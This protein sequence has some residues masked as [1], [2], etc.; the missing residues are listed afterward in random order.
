[1]TRVDM[2]RW[3]VVAY[4]DETGLGSMARDIKAVLGV[5]QLVVPSDRLETNRLDERR[6]HLLTPDMPEEQLEAIIRPLQGIVVLERVNW[7]PRLMA[8]CRRHGVAVVCVPMWE[9]FRGSDA[10]WREGDLF[11]CPSAFCREHV[12]RY[13]FSNA[14]VIPW[15]L[16]ISKLPARNVSGVGR[17]FFHNGGL[18]DSDDRK[19]TRTAISAFTRWRRKDVRLIVRLQK[20]PDTLPCMDD[21]IELKIGNVPDKALLYHEGD[22]ALQPSKME[23]LGFGILEPVVCG[24]P[25]ITLNY[26]PMSEYVIHKQIR[27]GKLPFKR[28][29][30]ARRAAGIKHA[31]LRLPSQS[32]LIDAMEW[33]ASNDLAAISMANR[34]WAMERFSPAHLKQLW[35]DALGMALHS[36]GKVRVSKNERIAAL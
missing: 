2:S 12:Q 28:T 9:W 29:C 4:N 35:S 33:C 31:H 8:V 26:P 17:V 19:G 15:A 27:V 21:R 20:Q 11:A 1:M 16:D 14:V 5:N 23:G 25:T 7:H 13:G 24:I 22:V 10:D 30:F 32:S 18:M 3:A 6:D 34:S 36:C